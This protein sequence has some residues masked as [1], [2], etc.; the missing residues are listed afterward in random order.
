MIKKES[1][2][3]KNEVE[4]IKNMPFGKQVMFDDVDCNSLYI[5]KILENERNSAEM[6]INILKG[7][8]KKQ[9]YS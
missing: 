8:F 9:P 2:I 3:E 4:I 5:Q 1:K 7:S 6:I